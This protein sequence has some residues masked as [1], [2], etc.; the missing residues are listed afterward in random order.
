[1]QF[2]L[3]SNFKFTENCVCIKNGIFWNSL[4]YKEGVNESNESRLRN[5]NLQKTE[6]LYFTLPRM[7]DFFSFIRS[8]TLPESLSTIYA[9]LTII[10]SVKNETG[11]EI[12]L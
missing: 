10:S 8:P 12:W 7:A 3:I 4:L 5:E 1:M 11:H 6:T 9:Y 2:K